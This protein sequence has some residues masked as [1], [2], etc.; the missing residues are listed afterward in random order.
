VT[1]FVEIGPG[2]V[3]SALAQGCLDDPA[4]TRAARVSATRRATGAVPCGTS[5]RTRLHR[6]AGQR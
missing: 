3:L 5:A 4:R 6:R 1:T 2:G